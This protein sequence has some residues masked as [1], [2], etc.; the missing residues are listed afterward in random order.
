MDRQDKAT[1]AVVVLQ[2][3]SRPSVL[4]RNV[5]LTLSVGQQGGYAGGQGY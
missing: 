2:F 3:P 4:P 5:V 1:A